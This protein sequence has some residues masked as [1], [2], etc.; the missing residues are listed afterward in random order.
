MNDFFVQ[1]EDSHRPMGI[2]WWF[3]VDINNH[4]CLNFTWKFSM[5]DTHNL[6]E[7]FE[8]E[9]KYRAETN[10]W[11]SIRAVMIRD[12]FFYYLKNPNPF[13]E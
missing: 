7:R 12:F 5:N 8:I 10:T 6:K 11:L 13:L 3:F 4:G 9:L 2:F 1:T